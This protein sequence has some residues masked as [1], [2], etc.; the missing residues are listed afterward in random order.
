M[1]N[2]LF[3]NQLQL[4]LA[5]ALSAAVVAYL[6]VLVARSRRVHI[7]SEAAIAF[8]RGLVQ[9]VAVGSVLVIMLRAPRWTGVFLLAA[10]IIAAGATSAK[11]AKGVPGSFEVSTYSIACG[12]GS[13]IAMMTWLGVIGTAITTLIPVGSMLIANAMNTNSLALNRFR[14]DVLAH[15][16]KSKLRWHWAR[17]RGRASAL[18]CRRRLR[19][20]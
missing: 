13:V 1:L 15:V 5:Q 11:R 3:T 12:A 2:R 16:G 6:V 17:I 9:I 10:M 8:V 18:M 7:E 20:A 19:R 14:S 4:G